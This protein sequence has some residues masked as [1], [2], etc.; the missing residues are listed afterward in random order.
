M[1]PNSNPALFQDRQPTRRL[2]AYLTAGDPSP[3]TTPDL[4]AALERG[5]A[6]LIELGV[7]FSDPIADGPVIQRGA[8]RALKAGTTLAKVLEIARTDPQDVGNS[9]AA[10]HLSESGDAL[11]VRKAGA[12]RE[13]RRH[14]RL[15]AHRPQRRRSRA[16]R[17]RHARRRSRHGFSCR[18]HLHAAAAEAGRGI[19]HRLRLSGLAHGRHRR[20][21]LPFRIG[22]CRWSTP[23]ARSP[24]CRWPWASE[25]RRRSKLARWPRSRRWRWWWAA[26]SCA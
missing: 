1:T 26:R 8:D 13:S 10:V 25:S 6:D 21:R 20:A 16:I 3:R 5:G 9:A 7:P 15:P 2:I 11:R 22:R 19:F 18:A 24:I 17:R 4:V 23:C 12:R 14:R